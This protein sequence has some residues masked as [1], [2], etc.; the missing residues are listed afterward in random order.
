MS[1]LSRIY[2][3]V[4]DSAQT[5]L[6][7]AAVFLVIYLFLFRPFQVNGA[8][9]EPN[10][11]NQ[12]YVLTNLIALRFSKPQRG[13]V[14]V[15]KAS[16]TNDQ[17]DFIKRVIGEPGDIVF[18]SNGDV[19]VNNEKLDES[20]Y[21]APAVKTYGGSFL[22]EGK[23]LL[24][25]QGHYIVFGDNRGQSSDSREWGFIDEKSIIGTSFYVYWPVQQMRL[26]KNPFTN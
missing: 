20:A 14:V 9:M 15:F 7:A 18:I 4:V 25:P 3:F 2:S 26:I 22:A 5:F 16:V 23:T 13:D 17:K 24:V 12:E 19:Y 10:F 6:L 11:E 21:L 8:S 1:L